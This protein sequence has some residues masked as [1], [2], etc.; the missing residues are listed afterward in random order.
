MNL[1]TENLSRFIKW[2][3]L[4]LAT[5]HTLKHR[6][7]IKEEYRP[8]SLLDEKIS[9]QDDNFEL[10]IRDVCEAIISNEDI[11][12]LFQKLQSEDESEDD[13]DEKD[14]NENKENLF[15][16]VISFIGLYEIESL[17]GDD[18]DYFMVMFYEYISD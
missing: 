1:N 18:I 5:N 7:Y 12:T 13:E 9:E 14:E 15:H 8:K 6:N 11:C 4:Q 17:H 16:E 2:S 3:L 10:G